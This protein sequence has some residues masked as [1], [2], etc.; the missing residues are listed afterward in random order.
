MKKL[1]FFIVAVGS[2]TL[3]VYATTYFI[4]TIEVE[5]EVIERREIR[6]E[7]SIVPAVDEVF[8]A[9][10]LIEVERQGRVGGSG[11]GFV[12]RTDDDYGYIITNYHVIENAE[13]LLIVL[14]D[15]TELEV[16]LV[17]KDLFTDLAVLRM[18]EENVLKIASL[19]DSQEMDLGEQVFTVG[20]PLGR[21]YI[22]TVT[23]GVLS[24]KSRLIEA[25]MGNQKV[26]FDLLQTDAAINPG[27]SGGPL[28]NDRGEVIGVNSMK[29]V[30]DTI[31]GM[32]F[33]IPIEK[34]ME[35]VEVL[36]KGEEMQRPL[37]GVML[38]DANDPLGLA[39][40]RIVLDREFDHGVVIVDVLDDSDADRGGIQE[41]DVILKINGEEIKNSPHFRFLLFESEVG[42]EITLEIYRDGNFIELEVK[43]DSILELD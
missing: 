12:Y 28:V 16:E 34:A 37:L 5:K 3:G 30:Q 38:V 10:V 32:G 43:L 4:G 15:E 39:Y 13:R 24:A 2:F 17:G 25:N 23:K 8:E 26:L 11:T 42:D 7:D 9:V 36:E 33:A 29:I 40:N 21:Q 22:G 41:Q 20:S 27:N 1:L 18:P 35:I 31:E 14:T 19:G 6:G